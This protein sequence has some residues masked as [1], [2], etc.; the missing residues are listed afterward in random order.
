MG[1]V[2]EAEP[3]MSTHMNDMTEVEQPDRKRPR[4]ARGV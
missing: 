1:E 4:G 3:H 2:P